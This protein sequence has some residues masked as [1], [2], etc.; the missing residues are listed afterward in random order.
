MP[1]WSACRP[2]GL[3]G[4]EP[5]QPWQWEAGTGGAKGVGGGAARGL[6]LA[7]PPRLDGPLGLAARHPGIEHHGKKRPENKEAWQPTLA[8]AG[9]ILEFAQKGSGEKRPGRGFQIMK[10]TDSGEAL[11]GRFEG[12]RL[13]PEGRKPRVEDGMIVHVKH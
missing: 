13:L 6:F 2:V 4:M 9:Q 10:L 11:P 8:A 12:G 5:L 3:S 1:S 7:H